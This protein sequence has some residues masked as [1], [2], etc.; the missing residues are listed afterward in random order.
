LVLLSMLTPS[1]GFA[2][3]QPQPPQGPLFTVLIFE[4]TSDLARRSDAAKSD[5]YWTAYDEF[6]GFLAQQGALRGGSALSETSSALVRGRRGADAGDIRLGGYF[7]IAAADLATAQRLAARAPA[8]AVAV[9]V[10]P[11]RDNPHMM[12]P[13]GN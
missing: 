2:Q 5:A 4:R 1:R 9:D 3:P 6:A 12:K 7:V 11:H 8:F 13:A 10:R